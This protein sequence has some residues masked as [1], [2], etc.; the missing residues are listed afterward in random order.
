MCDGA[1]DQLELLPIQLLAPRARSRLTQNFQNKQ[2]NLE[3]VYALATLRIGVVDHEQ[4][5]SLAL[6]VHPMG[7]ERYSLWKPL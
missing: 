1:Q 3:D 2:T 5:S 7:A 4:L 6:E